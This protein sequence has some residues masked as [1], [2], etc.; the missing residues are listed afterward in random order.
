MNCNIITSDQFSQVDEGQFYQRICFQYGDMLVGAGNLAVLER[1][2]SE[3]A[4]R[5]TMD[6]KISYSSQR[7]RVAIMVSK[8]DHCLYDLLIRHESGEL[9]CDIPIIV[10]NWPDLAPVAAKFGVE[11]HCLPIDPKVPGAKMEQEKAL[12]ALLEEHTIDTIVLARYMQIFSEE[13]AAKWWKNTIN[14]R[15]NHFSCF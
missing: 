14:V 8:M 4:A 13:M 5:F 15:N 1:G 6:W 11:Y 2:I 10:S 9:D 12:Q 7:K 3:V